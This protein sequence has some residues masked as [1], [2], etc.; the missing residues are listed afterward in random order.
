MPRSTWTSLDLQVERRRLLMR[1]NY[2]L[3]DYE[4]VQ[5]KNLVLLQA[6]HF[7]VKVFLGASLAKL[8]VELVTAMQSLGDRAEYVRIAGNGPNALDFHVAYYIG[9]LAALDSEPFFHIISKD[10]GFDPLI[11]HLKDK[12]IFCKR[13]T[14]LEAIPVLRTLTEAPRDEQID[15]VIEKL[16][17]MPKSRPQKDQTLRKMISAWFGNKLDSAA[18]DRIVGELTRRKVIILDQGKVRYALPA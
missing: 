6:E 4:N 2:V 8:P 11:A 7:K 1:T 14:A 16:K 12:G 10:T 18:L 3:I 5:P 17:G 9:R 15:G 13:S